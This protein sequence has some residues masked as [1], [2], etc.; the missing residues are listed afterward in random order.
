MDAITALDD[1]EEDVVIDENAKSIDIIVGFPDE[2]DDTDEDSD[3][4]ERP[5][6]E[7]AHF[8]RRILQAPCQV[9]GF[10]IADATDSQL[11]TSVDVPTPA[12][13]SKTTKK[14][15][16]N[17]KKGPSP[18]SLLLPEP[19]TQ[20]HDDEQ[21]KLDN[22]F[23]PIDYFLL[24]F[25]DDIL[26]LIVDESNLYAQKKGVSLNLD[27]DDL[28]KVLGILLLS[29]YNHVPSFR[30]Y[31][32]SNI[33]LKNDLVASSMSRDR[34]LLI[35]KHL[36]F[37]HESDAA[38]KAWKV[39]PLMNHFNSVFEK[40]VQ[41]NHFLSVDE[42]MIEY[43][44]PHPGKQFIK[45]KPIRYGF[46]VWTLCSSTGP[47]HRFDLYTGKSERQDGVGLGE[48][49]VMKL[50]SSVPPGCHIFMDQYFTSISLLQHMTAQM[51]GGT[52]TI[53][54]NRLRGAQDALITENE[55][56]KQQRGSSEEVSTTDGIN[57]VQWLDNRIVTVASNLLQIEPVSSCKRFSK[58][59]KKDINITRPNIVKC[60]N[61]HMGGVDLL[62]QA[63]NCYRIRVRIR[64]WYWKIFTWMI[65]L[66]CTNAYFQSTMRKKT[67]S[68]EFRRSVVM[69]LLS[70]NTYLHKPAS[71]REQRH[72]I[73]R[74][75][76]PRRLRCKVCSSH[77]IYYCASCN[78]SL[79]PD[80]FS[81][82][83]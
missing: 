40:Y 75:D 82:Y 42:S 23:E 35:I 1:D 10:S 48:G 31:W 21:L 8:G 76:P 67:T 60:Y 24:F 30:M 5:D 69:S 4:E 74:H 81:K 47:C 52:G 39:R 17:W 57:V 83:H 20:L 7:P 36:H 37:A 18:P 65:D 79:H 73:K 80:C 2:V 28:L 26:N 56:K 54:R 77:T 6:A 25:D 33:D 59:A 32:S 68:L 19:R 51:I 29:G 3:H 9:T 61:R 53:Q 15:Q 22:S 27:K 44:G 34:F 46:K 16:L 72:I 66:A 43:F 14:E 55:L 64:K 62:N 38:D 13:R 11:P 70:K 45:G 63:I 41:M 78:V 12:K 71:L 58:A 49:V 50:S